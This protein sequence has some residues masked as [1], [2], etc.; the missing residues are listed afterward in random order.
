MGGAT[1]PMPGSIICAVDGSEPAQGA[2]RV[3]R[4]L[5]ALMGARLLFVRVVEPGTPPERIDA[6]AA[7]LRGQVQAGAHD[8][9][10]N[11]QFSYIQPSLTRPAIQGTAEYRCG[12]FVAIGTPAFVATPGEIA[13]DSFALRP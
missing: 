5:G 2:I 13:D 6:I 10:Q 1:T 3:A 8:G 4:D 7:F 12:K 11:I 9:N